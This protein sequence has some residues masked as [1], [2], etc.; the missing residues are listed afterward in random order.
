M[1]LDRLRGL[2]GSLENS[3]AKNRRGSEGNRRNP[4]AVKKPIEGRPMSPDDPGNRN[5]NQ[6]LPHVDLI[7]RPD[8]Q[9]P[10]VRY[11]RIGDMRIPEKG[12]FF[13][14]PGGGVRTMEFRDRNGNRIDDRDEPGGSHYNEEA[15]KRKL[16]RQEE[17]K[18]EEAAKEKS[19]TASTN[20][21]GKD[22]EAMLRARMSKF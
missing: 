14:I 10:G 11:D 21:K 18:A 13:G 4:P 3:R 9:V 16:Q 7:G 6:S 1:S 8:R 15:Y 2:L 17:R 19:P 22:F 5:F 20:N 12:K